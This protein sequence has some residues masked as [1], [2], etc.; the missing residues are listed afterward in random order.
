MRLPARLGNRVT[1]P[2]GRRTLDPLLQPLTAQ[3]PAVVYFNATQTDQQM[4]AVLN[5]PENL[6]KN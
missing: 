3:P 1:G 5:L 6:Y 2:G 4:Q